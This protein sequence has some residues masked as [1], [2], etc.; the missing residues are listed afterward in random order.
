MDFILFYLACMFCGHGPQVKNNDA[1][2]L[3]AEGG[4]GIILPDGLTTAIPRWTGL[5]HALGVES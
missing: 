4:R 1:K 3:L 5:A 2:K